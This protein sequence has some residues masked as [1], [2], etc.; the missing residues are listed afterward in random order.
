[1]SVSTNHLRDLVEQEADFLE[2]DYAR[3]EDE[4]T[5][6]DGTAVRVIGKDA[7]T[8]AEQVGFVVAHPGTPDGDMQFKN[9]VK[10]GLRNMRDYLRGDDVEEVNDD[11]DEEELDELEKL[12]QKEEDGEI[13]REERSERTRDPEPA[14][15]QQTRRVPADADADVTLELTIDEDAMTDLET[16]LADVVD[17]QSDRIDDLEERIEAIESTF[18]QIGN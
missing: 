14:Q 3:V 5:K 6:G 15:T 11:D 1:M 17:D 2:I 8:E 7:P 18:S 9:Q 4:Q 12:A 13:E 10:S 16:Q